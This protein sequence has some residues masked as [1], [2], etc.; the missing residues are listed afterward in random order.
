ML[1][2]GT[3]YYN[4]GKLDIFNLSTL[5]HIA[6]LRA[7]A[8]QVTWVGLK[9]LLVLGCYYSSD[10]SS[11]S[12]DLVIGGAP[13]EDN[14]IGAVYVWDTAGN[15]QFKITNPDNTSNRFGGAVAVGG[16]VIVVGAPYS[17]NCRSYWF[18]LS[19]NLLKSTGAGKPGAQSESNLYSDGYGQSIA[20][21]NGMIY[22]GVPLG[23]VS[24]TQGGQIEYWSIA[25]QS[26]LGRITPSFSHIMV[27]ILDAVWQLVV[28]I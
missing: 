26:Y 3:N 17:S 28:G 8:N 20:I 21:N 7:D 13:R 16:D 6:T 18:D 19:G 24:S 11:R 5:D 27:I 23:D 10:G 9:I 2:G 4:S 25:N 15:F 22:I 1:S 12:R 14:N